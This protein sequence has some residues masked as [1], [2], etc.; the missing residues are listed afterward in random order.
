MESDPLAE[1][2][3]DPP[4][5]GNIEDK[6]RNAAIAVTTMQTL[7]FKFMTILLDVPLMLPC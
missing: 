3:V 7:R 4:V 2:P 1:Q 6:I 5:A